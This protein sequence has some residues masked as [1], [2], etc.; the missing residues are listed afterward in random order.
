MLTI[1]QLRVLAHAIRGSGISDKDSDVVEQDLINLGFN[2]PSAQ[3]ILHLL[4]QEDQLQWYLSGAIANDCCP[5]TRVSAGYPLQLRMRLGMDCPGCLWAKGDVTL[6]D[7]PKIALVGSRD[8]HRENTRFAHQVGVQA[9]EQGYTLV[10]GNARGADITAQEA[11]L[12]A[13]GHVISVVADRLVDH[14]LR[15][16]VLYLSEDA[17]DMGFSA[18]RALSRNRVIHAMAQAVLVAQCTLGKGGTWSG[19]V[20]NLKE[21]WSPV[22]CYED[23]SEA[24][25]QLMQMGANPI[26]FEQL[27]SLASL[28]PEQNLFDQSQNP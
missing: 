28:Q 6:L 20:K 26:M 23:S 25:T 18:Q 3:R 11:C 5:I 14:P 12:E 2:R 27:K 10:S 16:G 21:N 8:L 22:F 4:S 24:V 13:G 9:A 19:T 7:T 1:P 15:E 17:Y